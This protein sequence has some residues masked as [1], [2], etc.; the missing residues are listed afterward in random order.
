MLREPGGPERLVLEELPEP[1][2]RPGQAV[3]AVH[4]AGINFLDVLVRQG[5]YPQPPPLPTVLGIEIAGEVVTGSDGLAA[6]Q[7]VLGLTA[8]GVGG[9]YAER[10]L[11]DTRWLVPLPDGVSFVQGA[12]FLMTFL[13]AYIP[14]TRQATVGPGSVVLVHAAAGGVGTAAV[15]VARHLGARVVA[16]AGSEEKLKL[17]RELGAEIAID[18][19]AEDFA[20][21]VREEVGAVDV[22]VDPVGG[23]VL[24]ESLPLLRPLGVL[25][26]IGFAG[27]PWE[28]LDPTLLVGRNIGVQGFYLGRL[29]GRSP[30]VVQAAI[31]D[32]VELWRIGAIRP[33][34]GAEYPLEQ[35]AEAHRLVE[36]RHSTGKV[37]LTP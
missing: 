9:G 19:R 13:T 18:Y 31:V 21:R 4:A 25:I 22:V 33:V 7:R 16:T 34:V 32:L 8:P 2:A 10:A 29:L 14:L 12:S 26:A 20:A 35:A 15:Q 1:E 30:E 24:A 17:A 11:A 36:D 28:P 3:V 6:G 27:G 37:V 5:R 23:S